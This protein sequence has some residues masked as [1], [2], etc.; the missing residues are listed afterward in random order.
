[1]PQLLHFP[2]KR[3]QILYPLS[4]QLLRRA[5]KNM[6]YDVESH[7]QATAINENLHWQRKAKQGAHV[8]VLDHP[9]KYVETSSGNH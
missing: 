2:Q 4:V 7:A 6:L 1:M 5:Q 3:L 9:S 8:K